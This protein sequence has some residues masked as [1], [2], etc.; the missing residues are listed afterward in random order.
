MQAICQN[1]LAVLGGSCNMAVPCDVQ[2]YMLALA[3]FWRS[4]W[5]QICK[6]WL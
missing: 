2:V 4:Q 3:P 5:E 6:R 1:S